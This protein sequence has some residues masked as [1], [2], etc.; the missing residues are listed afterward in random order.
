MRSELTQF[1]TK[2]I[3]FSSV[4]NAQ[5]KLARFFAIAFILILGQSGRLL[6]DTIYFTDGSVL[7]VEKAR[8]EKDWVEY[9]TSDGMKTIP[10]SSVQRIYQEK[11]TAST[12]SPSRR[13]GIG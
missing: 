1:L 10:K 7:V 4:E 2:P 13:Y 9:Q 8:E 5:I 6:G 12:G 11:S 3:L